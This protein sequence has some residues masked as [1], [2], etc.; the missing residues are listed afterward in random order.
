[1]ERRGWTSEVSLPLLD[2]HRAFLVVI[3]GAIG[4]LGGTKRH[5]LGDD[6]GDGFRVGTNG[7]GAG[8]AA[9]RPQPRL[10]KLRFFAGERDELLLDGEQSVAP[11]IHGATL[12]SPS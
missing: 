9:Q 6:V 4:A 5:E 3:D 7:A 8:A 1:M 2:L 12:C 10:Y 11:H